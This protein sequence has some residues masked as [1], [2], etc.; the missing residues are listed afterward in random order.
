MVKHI[1]P[2][3]VALSVCFIWTGSLST[4]EQQKSLLFIP[5]NHKLKYPDYKS[6]IQRLKYFGPRLGGY[7]GP[8]RLDLLEKETETLQQKWLKKDMLLY[9]DLT[10]QVC[11]ILSA[12]L[13][14]DSLREDKLQVKYAMHAL[15]KAR[16]KNAVEMPLETEIKLLYKIM[17]EPEY[18]EGKLRGEDWAKRRLE[19]MQRFAHASQRLEKEID[20]DFDI[21]VRLPSHPSPPDGVGFWVSGMGPESIKDP[22]LRAEYEKR[23]A[24]HKRK[25]EERSRQRDFRKL[26]E[27]FN[28]LV[29]WYSVYAYLIPPYNT[30]EL[31]AYLQ[32][33]IK[34]QKEKESV[35][36][37][38]AEGLQRKSQKK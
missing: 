20:E 5:Y 23:L 30:G 35:L 12:N 26:R 16:E 31:E 21:S 38:Y 13:S 9:Y 15:K 10:F 14:D 6:D 7:R 19:K 4:A 3:L 25:V 8:D 27:S 34:D 11:K 32:K 2:L 37:R 22:K 28:R 1:T 36:K 33:Y 29:G 24:E 18:F 17:A